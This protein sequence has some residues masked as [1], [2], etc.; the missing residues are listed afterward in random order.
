MKPYQTA[1]DEFKGIA[2]I[3]L[4]ANENPFGSGLNRYPAANPVELKSAIAKLKEVKTEQ[5]FLGNGSDEAID[6]LYRS[7]CR[8]GI[9]KAVIFTPTYGMYEVSAAANDVEVIHVPLRRPDFSLPDVSTT[10]EQTREANLMFICSPN[11]PTG[12]LMNKET[13][14]KLASAFK[15]LVVVDEAYVDFSHEGS[16]IPEL[17]TLPNLVV[18]QTLSKAWGM[19]GIRLGMAFANEEVIAILN[20]IKPPYNINSLTLQKALTTLQHKEEKERTVRILLNEKQKME[21][22]L[23]KLANVKK[24]Y[25]GDANFLLVEF[26]GA[27]MVYN[28]LIK[29]GIIVRDRTSVVDN[30]FRITIGTPEENKVLLNELIH[31]SNEESIVY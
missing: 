12:N 31:I 16:L 8:P 30:C 5:L 1:R 28:N 25:P 15:G 13:I 17:E 10:I 20:K 6:L 14:K 9:D 29:K 27:G 19:A 11:N 2:S 23:G 22:E 7:F 21:F 18:L 4:D 24:I 26:N 3:Y